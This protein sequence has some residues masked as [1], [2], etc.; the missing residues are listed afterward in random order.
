M[1][2]FKTYVATSTQLDPLDQKTSLN[3]FNI[4]K[5]QHSPHAKQQMTLGYHLARSRKEETETSFYQRPDSSNEEL[6]DD[7]E[8]SIN[9]PNNQSLLACL[10]GAINHFQYRKPKQL[11]RASLAGDSDVFALMREN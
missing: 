5:T 3:Y 1:N 7:S 11:P 9:N 10:S 6:L 4:T 8:N 2:E